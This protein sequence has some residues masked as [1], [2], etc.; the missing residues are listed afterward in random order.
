M[1]PIV[2]TINPNYYPNNPNQGIIKNNQYSIISPNLYPTNLNANFNGYNNQYQYSR[3]NLRGIDS[4]QY[5]QNNQIPSQTG[6]F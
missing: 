3:N 1:S 2:R 4:G 6:T 5:Y